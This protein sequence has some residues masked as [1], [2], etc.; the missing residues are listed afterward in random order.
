MRA[1]TFHPISI[2]LFT[3]SPYAR[4]G[5]QV[6][7]W[8]LVAVDS[9]FLRLHFTDTVL[10]ACPCYYLQKVQYAPWCFYTAH[11]NSSSIH[12]SRAILKERVICA[13]S[14]RYHLVKNNNKIRVRQGR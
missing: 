13:A 2:I 12:S 6:C 4:W 7:V 8:Y 11:L 3:T 14:A 5:E 10:L 1:C 9:V